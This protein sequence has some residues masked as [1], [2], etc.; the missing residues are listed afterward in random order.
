MKI[1][2]IDT[3]SVKVP[4]TFGGSHQGEGLRTWTTNNILLVRVE[5]DTGIVGWGE[6]FCYACTDAVRAALHNMIAPLAIGQ[7]ARDI[8]KLSYGL[9]QKLH[10]FGR[11]GITIFALSGLDIAL[12]DIAGKAA[13]LPLH[14]LLGG[15]ARDS[16]PAY[17]SLL[18]YRDAERVAA[19]TKQAVDEGYRHIKLHETEEAEVKAARLAAGDDIAL[20]V[21]TNCPWTPEQARLMTLKLRPYGLFWLEEPIFPPE[22]FAALA[23]LR[24]GTGVPVAAGE[25]NCTSFQFRDMFAAGAVNYAQPSATKVGGVT[26]FLKVATLAEA[27]GVTLMPHSP[28]FGPGF[29][30]TLQIMAAHGGP[31][32]MIERYHM[33]LEASLYGGLVNPVKGAFIVP[34]GPGL[35]C[36]PDPDVLK[37]YGS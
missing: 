35:G 25:N 5:T 27:A 3:H 34:T 16:L 33:D 2:R 21:D 18:K 9:Q 11:Y 29:L 12:W 36:D 15:A 1:A 37:T 20:M 13:N 14:R 4:Y 28:Y 32:G 10:L 31:D 6:A 24:Q 7:D 26:E 22:D 30:A 19:R 8:A 17:A 23:R